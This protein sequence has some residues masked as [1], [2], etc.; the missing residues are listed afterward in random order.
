METT[1][2]LEKNFRT[3]L[4][5]NRSCG[6]VKERLEKTEPSEE[7]KNLTVYKFDNGNIRIEVGHNK[8]PK[9]TKY[10]ELI[11]FFGNKK[12]LQKM[13]QGIAIYSKK[14]RG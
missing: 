5:Y 3:W 1:L 12:G 11:H 10:Y 13:T 2:K 8:I 7:K 14:A 6:K 9:D 4:N